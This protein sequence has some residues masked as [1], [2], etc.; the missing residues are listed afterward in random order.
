MS[1][2][3]CV[4]VQIEHLPDLAL[5]IFTVLEM[6]KPQYVLLSE[7]LVGGTLFDSHKRK[8]MTRENTES[9][10]LKLVV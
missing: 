8:I 5:K 1:H 7:I 6:C 9:S 4:Y 3:I 10:A 2:S